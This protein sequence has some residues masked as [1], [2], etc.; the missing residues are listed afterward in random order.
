MFQMSVACETQFAQ[1]FY[2]DKKHAHLA[3]D[4][5]QTIKNMIHSDVCAPCKHKIEN[6]MPYIFPEYLYVHLIDKIND[7]PDFHILIC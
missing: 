4:V 1:S 5:K 7:N 6:T 2:S 3:M